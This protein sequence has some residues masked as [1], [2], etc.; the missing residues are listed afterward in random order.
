MGKKSVRSDKTP[1]QLAREEA[2]LT[3]A[4]ADELMD[5]VSDSRIEKIE[6]GKSPAMREDALAMASAYGRPELIN[7]YCSHECPI[8]RKYVPEVSVRELPQI[9]LEILDAVNRVRD[10]QDSLI[11]IAADGDISDNEMHDFLRIRKKLTDLSGSVSELQ[12]WIDRAIARGRLDE[13]SIDEVSEDEP[14]VP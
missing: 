4:A 8:G 5:Y 3:R 9:V 13:S 1:Y 10:E 2:G 6:N 12:L 11:R 14:V 7:Y